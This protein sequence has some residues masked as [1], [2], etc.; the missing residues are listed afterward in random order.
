[1]KKIY[2]IYRIV[3]MDVLVPSR[4][5]YARGNDSSTEGVQLIKP[6]Y[7]GGV[8]FES[9]QDAEKYVEGI[10]NSEPTDDKDDYVI[11]PTYIK[12]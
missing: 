1:M 11:M 8:V 5:Y 6:I 4:D 9:E 10:F 12:K 2:V 7:T 3:N